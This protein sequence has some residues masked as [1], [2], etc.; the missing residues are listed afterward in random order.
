MRVKSRGIN[1]PEAK[2]KGDIA[3]YGKEKKTMN[4]ATCG[5]FLF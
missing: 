4:N 2:R 5:N 3:E 1:F